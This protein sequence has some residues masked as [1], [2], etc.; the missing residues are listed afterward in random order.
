M[1]QDSQNIKQKKRHGCLTVYLVLIIAGSSLSMFFIPLAATAPDPKIHLPAWLIVLEVFFAIF[2][3]VCAWALLGWKKWGF[4]GL[5]GSNA[6]GFVV[7]VI[8]GEL[9]IVAVINVI[10]STGILLWALNI[11]D[12]NKGWP[13]LE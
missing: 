10:I 3:I 7:L 4:W 9:V 1:L 13:Q 5:C 6:A 2:N 12:E 8:M 11:G